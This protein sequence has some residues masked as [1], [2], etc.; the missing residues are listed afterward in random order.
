MR[1]I[2]FF[3]AFE[4]EK[5]NSTQY[6]G[7]KDDLKEMIE[8]SLKTSDSKTFEDFISAYIK[9][10]ETTQ[11]QGLIN[12]SDIYEFY[13]KYRNDID[14]ILSDNSFFEKA[15]SDSD[16]FSLYDYIIVGTKRALKEIIT[17]L[18]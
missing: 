7:I 17:L 1:H 8:K 10:P 14:Q 16:S 4:E 15:P 9:D 3:E 2:K 5:N 13:L 11:I 12:D 6:D 18:K